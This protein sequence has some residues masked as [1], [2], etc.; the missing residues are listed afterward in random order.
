MQSSFPKQYLQIWHRHY[1]LNLWNTLNVLWKRAPHV[2]R[3]QKA[4]M[5]VLLGPPSHRQ[6]K[7]HH[8]K[9][10]NKTCVICKVR[11][12]SNLQP[13]CWEASQRRYDKV[14]IWV[15]IHARS[16]PDTL[17]HLRVMVLGLWRPVPSFRGFNRGRSDY[18]FDLC[19]CSAFSRNN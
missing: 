5:L 12:D 6:I 13:Y 7:L 14:T 19:L 1:K 4:F 3:L 10:N 15:C 11:R 8:T 18:L 16:C 17:L 2:Y 9:Q